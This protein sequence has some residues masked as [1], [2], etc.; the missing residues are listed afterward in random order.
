MSTITESFKQAELALAAYS[1]VTPGISGT[2]YTK[3]LEADGAGMSPAQA[4]HFSEQWLVVE[5]YADPLS[6]L[7]ATVFE[8]V[9]SGRRH[10]AV[11]GT[12]GLSDLFTDLIDIALLGTP[13]RQAQ[14]AALKDKLAEWL[15]NGTLAPG[16][17]VS[18]HSL[19]GFLAGALLVDYPTEIG[20]AYLYNT[21]GVGGL[22]AALRVLLNLDH[23]PSLDLSRVTNLRAE[24]G[25]AMISGLGLAWGAPIPVTIEVGLNPIANHSIVTLTDALALYAAYAQLDPP[26]SVASLTDIL[27]ASTNRNGDTLEPAPD[28]EREL[29]KAA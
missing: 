25:G 5:Q 11:R 10:L 27:K 9:A 2:P 1:N 26:A 28:C 29:K 20:Q 23:E 6:G 16:F 3:A 12:E 4:E 19:G 18:G 8:E 22:S 17:S 15:G 21:P 7:S 14:Y 24:G 13:E